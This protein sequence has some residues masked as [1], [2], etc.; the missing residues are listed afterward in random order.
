MG[1]KF[2]LIMRPIQTKLALRI[3]GLF[4]GLALTHCGVKGP[5]RAE[6]AEEG[7]LTRW[8]ASGSSTAPSLNKDESEDEQR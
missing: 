3:L 4:A 7:P 6:S 2:E 5:P 8:E 1:A